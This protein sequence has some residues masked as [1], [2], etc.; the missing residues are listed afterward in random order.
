MLKSLFIQNYALIS[1]LKI[2]FPKNFSVITGETGSGKSVIIGALSLILGIRADIKTIIKQGENKCIIEGIFDISSY[3][4]QSFF[5]KKKLEYDAQNCILRRE[6]WNSGKSRAF[7]NDTPVGLNDLRELGFYLI[8]IHSQYKNLLLGDNSFQLQVL[9]TLA[10]NKNLKDEY[11]SVYS[12]FLS[13]YHQLQEL[14][15]KFKK[16]V[17]EQ[18][19]LLFQ[20]KQLEEA[21][22]KFGEQEELQKESETLS[23]IEEIKTGL[24]AIEQLLLGDNKGI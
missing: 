17:N 15:E 3:K 8:D 10:N 2:E 16:Y 18:D 5:D 23:H 9:D 13:V 7:I 14:K 22:L 4:F 11:K 6:V 21:N 20:F 24:F 19:Y 1:K 12:T